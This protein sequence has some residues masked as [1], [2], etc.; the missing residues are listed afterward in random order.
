MV[1]DLVI[2]LTRSQQ[3]ADRRDGLTHPDENNAPRATA[4]RPLTRSQPNATS[5]MWDSARAAPVVRY[6][7]H[8]PAGAKAGSPQPQ[9]VKKK[10][11][12]G[13]RSPGLRHVLGV[14]GEE[15]VTRSSG[16]RVPVNGVAAARPS[17]SCDRGPSSSTT[18]A[19]V[20]LR[21]TS[22]WYCPKS[23]LATGGVEKTPTG[24]PSS[25]ITSSP[26]D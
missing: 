17:A 20:V 21:V 5:A 2:H 10:P 12:T 4:T 23:W 19:L 22:P 18:G 13:A 1:S 25:S 15:R 6:P 11:R 8:W 24:G 16:D 7:Q 14:D 26:N 3:E 9:L